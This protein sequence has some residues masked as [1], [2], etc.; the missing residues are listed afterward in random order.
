MTRGDPGWR[1]HAVIAGGWVALGVWS[2]STGTGWLGAG[3]LALAAA[4]AAH[5][6]SIFWK[7]RRATPEDS[8]PQ[9]E[10]TDA[11]RPDRSSGRRSGPTALGRS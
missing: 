10:G 1:A 11:R 8:D 7:A 5:A 6:F 2:V 3:Q 9:N 4:T